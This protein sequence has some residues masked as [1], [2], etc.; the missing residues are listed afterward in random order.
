VLETYQAKQLTKITSKKA[1]SNISSKAVQEMEQDVINKTGGVSEEGVSDMDSKDTGKVNVDMGGQSNEM[2][3]SDSGEDA[4]DA[5]ND[6]GNGEDTEDSDVGEKGNDDSEDLN[7]E[8]AKASNDGE[9]G[10]NNDGDDSGSEDEE[11]TLTEE[12]SQA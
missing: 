12:G 5:V 4:G 11:Y 8:S 1:W 9:N 2:D 10:E 7:D 6:N 3:E